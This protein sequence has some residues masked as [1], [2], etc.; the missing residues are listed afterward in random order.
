MNALTPMS[1]Q[2][3][4]SVQYQANM[5]KVMKMKKSIN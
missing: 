1:D 3:R 2:D 5:M 4:M